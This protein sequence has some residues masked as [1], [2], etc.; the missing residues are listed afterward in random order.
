MAVDESERIRRLRIKAAEPEI[1]KARRNKRQKL[2]DNTDFCLFEYI[3][4]HI[5]KER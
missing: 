5:L 4:S 1:A 3:L 2:V